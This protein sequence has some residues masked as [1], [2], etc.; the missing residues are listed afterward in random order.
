[1]SGTGEDHHRHERQQNPEHPLRDARERRRGVLLVAIDRQARND[2]RE[3]RIERLVDF[4]QTAGD[5]DGRAVNAERGQRDTG[6]ASD[7]ASQHDDVQTNDDRVEQIVSADRRRV[8]EQPAGFRAVGK[9]GRCG[10]A[11]R[12]SDAAKKKCDDT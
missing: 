11:E 7:K 12:K 3:D 6:R 10:G 8:G 9:S 5:F 2:R 4:A 1:M